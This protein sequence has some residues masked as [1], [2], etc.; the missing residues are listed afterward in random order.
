MFARVYSSRTSYI[1]HH[2]FSP[3]A[4]KCNNSLYWSV[5][6]FVT[7][8]FVVSLGLVIVMSEALGDDSL[9]S[10]LMVATVWEAD[11]FYAVFCKHQVSKIFF[12]M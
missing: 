9:F 2:I 7:T 1:K 6:F 12:P 4:S 10:L 11:Q 3:Q 8:I 5:L